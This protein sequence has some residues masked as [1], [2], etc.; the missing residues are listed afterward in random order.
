M[1]INKGRQAASRGSLWSDEARVSGLC[2]ETCVAGE[3]R[4]REV[5]HVH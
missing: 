4:A 3:E 5:G 1:P 2:P